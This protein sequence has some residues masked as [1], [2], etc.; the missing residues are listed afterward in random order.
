MKGKTMSKRLTKQDFDAGKPF[1]CW[2]REEMS[3]EICAHIFGGENRGL[4]KKH[5]AHVDESTEHFVTENVGSL[6]DYPAELRAV[7]VDI[8][9]AELDPTFEN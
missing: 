3:A 7:A 8:I 9:R 6:D 4:I 2:L 1:S 5:G